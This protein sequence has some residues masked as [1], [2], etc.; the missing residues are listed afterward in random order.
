MFEHG[1][2]SYRSGVFVHSLTFYIENLDSID[3][4]ALPS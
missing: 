4:C 1:D 3:F 2:Y